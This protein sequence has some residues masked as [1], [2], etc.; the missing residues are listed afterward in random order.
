MAE[1]KTGLSNI[2]STQVQKSNR[3]A[4]LENLKR[5]RLKLKV[6]EAQQDNGM[7]LLT[8]HDIDEALERLYQCPDPAGTADPSEWGAAG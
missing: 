1:S 3:E 2:R 6:A 7:L 5:L 4:V 8:R